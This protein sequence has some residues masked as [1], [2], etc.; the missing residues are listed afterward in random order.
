MKQVTA[1]AASIITLSLQ[2]CIETLPEWTS[3]YEGLE[4]TL[5]LFDKVKDESIFDLP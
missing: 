5:F 2:G 3:E 1:I 4:E